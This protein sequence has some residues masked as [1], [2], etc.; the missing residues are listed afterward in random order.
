M[1]FIVGKDF[2]EDSPDMSNR[3][4]ASKIFNLKNLRRSITKH[5]NIKLNYIDKNIDVLNQITTLSK[6][7]PGNYKIVLHLISKLGKSQKILLSNIKI[8]CENYLITHSI[9]N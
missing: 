1:C 6:K 9:C 2:N 4:V 8:N 3:I 7:H 5:I